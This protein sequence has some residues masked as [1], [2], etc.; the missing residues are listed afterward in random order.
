M[1]ER[2]IEQKEDKFYLSIHVETKEGALEVPMAND[3]SF[4]VRTDGIY[5]EGKLTFWQDIICVLLVPKW[6]K[7]E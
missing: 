3:T 6:D 7:E 2:E 1:K 4:E 5:L